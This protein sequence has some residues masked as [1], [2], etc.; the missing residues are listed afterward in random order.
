MYFGIYLGQKSF[1]FILLPISRICSVFKLLWF[2]TFNIS[3]RSNKFGIW[4][5]ISWVNRPGLLKDSWISV[6]KFVVAPKNKV[7]WLFIKYS[8]NKIVKKQL[9]NQN[10]HMLRQKLWDIGLQKIIEII[11]NYLLRMLLCLIMSLQEEE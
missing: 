7:T 4:M 6:G 3:C 5:K 9:S 10:P 2:N 11:L 8:E 1:Q